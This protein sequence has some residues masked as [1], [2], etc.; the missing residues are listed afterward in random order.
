[1]YIHKEGH[2]IINI[3]A[4]IMSILLILIFAF[5]NVHIGIRI[6]LALP[7]ILLFL[8]IVSFFRIPKR[9]FTFGDNKIIAPADGKIVV[10][11]ET[12]EHEILKEKCRQISI[13]MSPA[14]VHVNRYPINGKVIS[15]KHHHGKYLVA[16]HPKSSLENERTT[17]Y[18]ET[19]N[20]TPIVLRQV[21]GALA[22]RIVCYAKREKVVE[23]N[24]EMGFIKFGSR[25]DIFLPLSAKIH[26]EL[27]QKV[28]NGISV[29]AELE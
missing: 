3:S 18:M 23:Q 15:S 16:S 10:I 20:G 17:V 9:V 7:F 21:A 4:V 5:T 8:A 22:R 6:L 27:N 14:N 26:V 11:E 24:Q 2:K 28:K 19:E 29:I 12:V 13:F 1:M 25:V